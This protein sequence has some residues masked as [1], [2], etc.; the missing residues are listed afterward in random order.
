[1]QWNL[2]CSINASHISSNNWLALVYKSSMSTEPIVYF[3]LA[4]FNER[5]YTC[6]VYKNIYTNSKQSQ[7]MIITSNTHT[8]CMQ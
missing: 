6:G 3:Y 8:Y 7:I 2:D 4:I 5:K 1:M